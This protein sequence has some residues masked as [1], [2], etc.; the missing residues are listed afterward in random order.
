MFFE[1]DHAVAEFGGSLEVEVGGGFAHLFLDVGDEL[2]EFLCVHGFGILLETGL[3]FGNL[4]RDGYEVTDSLAN[5]L[6]SD[7]VFLIVF[8][9][10]GPAA[11]S[12]IDGAA[13][14][15]CHVVGV[16]DDM[17]VG[18][19]GGAPDGLDEGGL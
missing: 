2:R 3:L 11:F 19:S 16:H 5:S 10:K 14:G 6:G 4:S 1:V 8:L 15:I 17:A 18:V 12:L 7:P 9:L 13:H